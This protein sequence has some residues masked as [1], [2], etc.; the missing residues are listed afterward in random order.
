VRK[1]SVQRIAFRLFA[2][3]AASTLARPLLSTTVEAVRAEE[4]LILKGDQTGSTIKIA[5]DYLPVT[6]NVATSIYANGS[7]QFALPDD[8]RLYPGHEEA[9]T[10]ERE[11]RLNP[12]NYEGTPWFD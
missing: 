9:T 10:V 4:P 12:I 5:H 3:I 11:K 2:A 1:H 6:W 8:Y 7:P